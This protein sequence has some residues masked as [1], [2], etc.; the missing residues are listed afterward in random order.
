MDNRLTF[1]PNLQKRKAIL[2]SVAEKNRT[3]KPRM[4]LSEILF[5]AALAIM[6][7]MG[8][9]LIIHP[10]SIEGIFVFLLTGVCLACVPFFIAQSVKNKA[11]YICGWP[12]SGYANG[13]LVLTEN[14]LEYIFWMVGPREPAAYS[15]PRAVF[16]DEDKF[17]F[18]I[19]KKDV[20][21]LKVDND[22]CYIKGIGKMVI[23]EWAEISKSELKKLEK[24][25]SFILA[26]E[27]DN[28][29]NQLLDFADN[30][31]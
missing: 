18:S 8:I 29:E 19:D 15:S 20:T 24:D 27:E 1:I 17:V 16:N 3:Y 21:S 31:K 28:V 30:I 25:F 26:F 9:L 13:Q 5:V 6:V 11:K 12:Y 14:K 22:V 10:I 23:P 7:S 4:V 2:K